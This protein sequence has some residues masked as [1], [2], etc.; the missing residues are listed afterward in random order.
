MGIWN[1]WTGPGTRG[2]APSPGIALKPAT[3]VL[4]WKIGDPLRNSLLGKQAQEKSVSQPS[5]PFTRIRLIP[6]R[7]SSLDLFS[8]APSTLLLIWESRQL[9]VFP[10]R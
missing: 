4:R 7:A 8:F 1:G 3:R 9:L 5:A 2:L 10:G 6:H